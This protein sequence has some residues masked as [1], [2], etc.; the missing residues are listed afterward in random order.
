M[1]TNEEIKTEMKM[2]RPCGRRHLWKIPIFIA[3]MILVQSVVVFFLW[4]SLIPDLFQGPHLTFIQALGLLVLVKAL[5]GSG[6]RKFGRGGPRGHWRKH[7]WANLSE[8]EREKFKA[9]FRR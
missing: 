3:V 6:F 5:F 9:K 1:N 2:R 7:W 8:E 4:N